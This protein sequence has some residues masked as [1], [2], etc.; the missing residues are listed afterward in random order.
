MTDSID[1]TVRSSTDSARSAS[2]AEIAKDWLKNYPAETMPDGVIVIY[3]NESGGEPIAYI[4]P[5]EDGLVRVNVDG[6]DYYISEDEIYPRSRSARRRAIEVA[7]ETE[8]V[9]GEDLVCEASETPFHESLPPEDE[10]CSPE[11]DIVSTQ[12][13]AKRF[14]ECWEDNVS[15]ESRFE[16]VERR[17]N[18]NR[19]EVV[20]WVG[21]VDE[22]RLQSVYEPVVYFE[23]SELAMSGYE[24]FE[25]DA[26]V[27]EMPGLESPEQDVMAADSPENSSS[28]EPVVEEAVVDVSAPDHGGDLEDAVPEI[29]ATAHTM[30]EDTGEVLDG[31]VALP[32][33]STSYEET[34]SVVFRS[35]LLSYELPSFVDNGTTVTTEISG[36]LAQVP[37][38]LLSTGAV[39]CCQEPAS[40]T[41]V[42]FGDFSTPP[43]P[44]GGIKTAGMTDEKTDGRHSLDTASQSHADSNRAFAA[45]DGA[46]S[47]GLKSSDGAIRQTHDAALR[48]AHGTAGS[49]NG[50]ERIASNAAS[51]DK[52][53]FDANSDAAAIAAA[54][55][56]GAPFVPA[57]HASKGHTPVEPREGRE[58]VARAGRDEQGHGRGQHDKDSDSREKRD[59]WWFVDLEDPEN[60]ESEEIA[61]S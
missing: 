55:P 7:T 34:N 28:S 41:S 25:Q 12:N 52:I 43:M 54:A 4:Y 16:P 18:P 44:S 60:L 38:T 9:S 1:R 6:V 33:A 40:Q 14:G 2:L 45:A 53:I 51:G 5:A 35:A 49:R 3:A 59:E 56:Q 48:Q 10:V 30:D 39:M 24:S 26:S 27:Y 42:G 37:G 50:H 29:T 61:C 46:R 21:R 13:S 47:D 32:L 23:D 31:S 57:A 15:G 22:D 58:Q 8:E 20:V 11:R 36:F 17:K 19:R